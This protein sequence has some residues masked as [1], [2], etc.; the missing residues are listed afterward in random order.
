MLVTKNQSE[1]TEK[2]KN[3]ARR[4]VKE[5]K[6]QAQERKIDPPGWPD[7]KRECHGRASIALRCHWHNK[8]PI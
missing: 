8:Q 3:C 1:S 7:P 5:S 4:R 6:A 2:Q